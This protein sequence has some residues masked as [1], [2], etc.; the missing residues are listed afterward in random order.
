MGMGA[1]PA[2]SGIGAEQNGMGGGS[3]PLPE[4]EAHTRESTNR[5]DWLCI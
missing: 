5:L 2:L 3:M 1:D 4:G